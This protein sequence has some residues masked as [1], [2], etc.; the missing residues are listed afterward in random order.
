MPHLL[1]VVTNKIHKN[2]DFSQVLSHTHS[3]T[4][5]VSSTALPKTTL[6]RNSSGNEIANVNF[7]YDDTI[8]ALQNT[9]DSCINTATDRRGYVLE[10][11]FNKFRDITQCNGHYA[12]RGRS[13]SP[14]L[15][16]IESSYTTSY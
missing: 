1:C 14:I 5:S 6:T 13:R 8:H 10:H 2:R 7:L 12:I 3:V 11:M 9:I 15:V 4:S 16:P